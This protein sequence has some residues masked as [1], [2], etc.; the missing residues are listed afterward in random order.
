M[1]KR[2]R[3]KTF[4]LLSS[5]ILLDIINKRGEKKSFMYA[6]QQQQLRISYRQ[7]D[8]IGLTQ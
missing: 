6:E 4:N 5:S 8:H 7:K 1:L 3:S 2:K